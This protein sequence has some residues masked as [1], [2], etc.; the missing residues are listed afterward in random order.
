IGKI[1]WV[2][3]NFGVLI[4]S[5]IEVATYRQ[6]KYENNGDGKPIVSSTS[7]LSAD[8]NRRDF[9]CNSLYLNLN[10]EV[11]DFHNGLQ[12]IKLGIIRAI[13]NPDRRFKEDASRILRAIYLAVKLKFQIEK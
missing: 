8:S 10:G 13:N 5:G 2:G 7:T 4:I 11:I 9:T 12:D 3:K 6:E 1:N